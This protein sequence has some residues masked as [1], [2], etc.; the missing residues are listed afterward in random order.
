MRLSIGPPVADISKDSRINSISEENH[1]CVKQ[2]EELKV[3]GRQ[4]DVEAVCILWK[5]AR[6]DQIDA[7]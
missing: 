4:G 5:R 3:E 2:Y 1:M 6:D 7:G